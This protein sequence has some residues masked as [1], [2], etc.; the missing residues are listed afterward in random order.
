MEP[1]IIS[2]E[3]VRYIASN[4]EETKRLEERMKLFF[5]SVEMRGFTMIQISTP[6]LSPLSAVVIK[7]WPDFVTRTID[8]IV[9]K[10][11]INYLGSSPRGV[12]IEIDSNKYHV[13]Y[14][15]KK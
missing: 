5:E 7:P 10:K 9:P 6:M 13:Y 4:T 1:T 11:P 14:A 12:S 8:S 15:R 2:H 3:Q